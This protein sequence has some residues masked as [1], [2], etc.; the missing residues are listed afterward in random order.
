[1]PSPLGGRRSG[2]LACF[3]GRATSVPDC[4]PR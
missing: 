4:L 3:S 1:M 2:Q